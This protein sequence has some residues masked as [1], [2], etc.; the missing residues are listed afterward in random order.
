VA[1]KTEMTRDERRTYLK[2]MH[3][4]YHQAHRVGRIARA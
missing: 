1:N 3:P 4:R 2:G